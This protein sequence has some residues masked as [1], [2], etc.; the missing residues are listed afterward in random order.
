[1]KK[2]EQYLEMHPYEIWQ[3]SN[4]KYYTYLPD[5]EKGRILKKR[6]KRKD[7][8]DIIINYYENLDDEIEII[9]KINKN[10]TL[11]ELYDVWKKYKSLHTNSSSYMKRI[12]SDWRSF[13]SNDPIADVQIETLT[14]IFIDEWFHKKIKDY[15]MTKTKFYNMSIIIRESLVYA[16]DRELIENNP[17]LE[18]KVDSR[19]FRGK[20]KKE[21]YEEV[22][23]T[24][25]EP[26]IKEYCRKRFESNPA[27]TT[28]LAILLMFELGCRSG[29]L[30][31]LSDASLR[32]KYVCFS[33]Q[34]VAEY[35][36][37]SGEFEYKG[38]KVVSY[39]KTET[40]DNRNV[41]ASVEARKLISQ[42][43]EA[44]MLNG[45]SDGSYLILN[46]N[47]RTHAE[48][49][50][51]A[52]GRYCNASGVS[53]KTTHK[54]RKTYISKAI[55]GNINIKKLMEMVGHSSAKTTYGNYCFDRN[56]ETEFEDKMER[57]LV[58]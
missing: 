38:T 17:C 41:Y 54:I 57:I 46:P 6:A 20:K 55:D 21:N 43:K 7:L 40:G 18:V 26:I 30:V 34:E 23:L 12:H 44:N 15:N 51:K 2:R 19:L 25:E 45:Y 16:K 3:G 49:I 22:F 42:I 36:M 29:E 53:H 10:M 52:L 14:K 39:T 4:G 56:T 9:N 13:Y 47:G 50:N 37:E 24:N 33:D 27:C 31:A 58:G 8:E 5:D 35:D 28:P 1:M 32:G 48:T 11:R